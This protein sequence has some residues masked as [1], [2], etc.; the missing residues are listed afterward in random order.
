MLGAD[1]PRRSVGLP[2]Q[3]ADLAGVDQGVPHTVLGQRGGRLVRRKALRGPV[4]RNA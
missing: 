2:T 4:E 3:R 1:R